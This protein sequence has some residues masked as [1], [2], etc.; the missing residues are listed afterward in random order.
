[1]TQMLI[2][3]QMKTNGLDANLAKKYTGTT[4]AAALT[5]PTLVEFNKTCSVMSLTNFALPIYE[6][7]LRC[8]AFINQVSQFKI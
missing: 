4:K 2:M 7:F 6:L 3:M 8:N 5:P 1:M